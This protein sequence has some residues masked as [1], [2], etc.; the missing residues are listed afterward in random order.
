MYDK[1]NLKSEPKKIDLMTYINKDKLNSI[2]ET[3]N[4]LGNGINLDQFIDFYQQV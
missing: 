2:N 1:S 4:R 3:F